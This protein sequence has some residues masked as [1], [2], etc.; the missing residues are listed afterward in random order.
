[1]LVCGLSTWGAHPK[2]TGP[3]L[4]AHP[5]AT[6]PYPTLSPHNHTRVPP[7]LWSDP[8][9]SPGSNCQVYT[10]SCR[11]SHCCSSCK[12]TAT[13]LLVRH[14]TVPMLALPRTARHQ[15]QCIWCRK[16]ANCSPHTSY[17]NCMSW[18]HHRCTAAEGRHTPSLL[19][20][21]LQHLSCSCQQQLPLWLAGTRVCQAGC[22]QAADAASPAPGMLPADR[23]SAAPAAVAQTWLHH[24]IRLHAQACAGSK[25]NTKPHIHDTT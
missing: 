10:S 4:G 15:A 17:S 8:P 22:Q 5:N 2:A 18:T 1:M 3:W 21:A 24:C 14:D 6:G 13:L 7:P 12:D 11:C 19:L 25:Q 16:P 9:P 23:S 20:R